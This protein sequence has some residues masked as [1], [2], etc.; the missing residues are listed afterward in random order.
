MM[1]QVSDPLLAVRSYVRAGLV[2]SLTL[3][4]GVGGWAYTTEIA[5]AVVAGGQV[6]A[7]TNVKKVAHVT[8][9][10][11][12]EIFVTDGTLVKQ[13]DLLI[14]LDETV[15]K[16]NL[17]IV[18]ANLR[19]TTVRLARLLAE[20]D[21]ASLIGFPPEVEAWRSDPEGARLLDSET[22]L[23]DLRR[24]SRL[25]QQSQ[26]RE[27]VGQIKEEIEGLTIQAA[28]KKREVEVMTK[29][30]EATRSLWAKNLIPL[31]RVTVIER[32][33]IR[34]EGDAGRLISSIAQSKGKISETQMQILQVDQEFRSE[35]ARELRDVQAKVVELSERR[36]AAED[37]LNRVEIRAPQDGYVHQLQV[38]S[39][40]AVI[41]PGTAIVSIVPSSD[42]LAIEAKVPVHQ[43][44]Q[45]HVGAKATF[46]LTSLNQ[47]TTPELYGEVYLVSA[48]AETE[49]RTGA[50]FYTVRVTL[51]EN[52]VKRLG[53]DVKLIPGMPAEVFIKTSD[54]T[55]LS[56]LVKPMS[57]QITRA[58]RER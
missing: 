55:V 18:T 30:L 54:R 6:I 21:D 44:D 20:R 31:N 28:A 34:T 29:E 36:I 16:A 42:K 4:F 49:E 3:L 26:L 53:T 45:V 7:E 51:P 50:T 2:V 56:Y 24:K 25:G 48:T 46:R 22:R 35:V 5:G 58:F 39:K 9:G 37:Q 23:F 1:D 57:D 38:F 52:E 43:I 17:G 14:K 47:R 12:G 8:G 32:D 15:P 41:T 11:V 13:G 19:E 33:A 40:G 10:N 27:R